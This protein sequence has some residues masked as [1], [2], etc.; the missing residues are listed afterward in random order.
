VPTALKPEVDMEPY[1][2][3]MCALPQSLLDKRE[4]M[5]V[6]VKKIQADWTEVAEYV[7]KICTKLGEGVRLTVTLVDT[8]LDKDKTPLGQKIERLK[9]K[10]ILSWSSRIRE[11]VNKALRR[12]HPPSLSYPWEKLFYGAARDLPCSCEGVW[13]KLLKSLTEL[14]GAHALRP[15][16]EYF[17]R[18]LGFDLPR[19]GR[20]R[21]LLFFGPASSGKSTLLQIVRSGFDWVREFSFGTGKFAFDGFDDSLHCLLATD[22]FRIGVGLNPQEFLVAVEG[23]RFRY[24]FV[25]RV[26]GIDRQ[27]HTRAGESLLLHANQNA[28]TEISHHR[29]EPIKKPPPSPRYERKGLSAVEAHADRAV[30]CCA[31]NTLAGDWTEADMNALRSRF[32]IIELTKAYVDTATRIPHGCCFCCVKKWVDGLLG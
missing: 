16:A 13:G 4:K 14:H 3:S 10:E 32:I 6:R 26:M 8:E 24:A 25:V 29:L 1:F 12:R 9:N 18:L 15:F 7:E 31:S 19:P 5:L 11:Y 30:F 2:T 27:K 22:D 21:N 23:R 17:R 28:H 20:P